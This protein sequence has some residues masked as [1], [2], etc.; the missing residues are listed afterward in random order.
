MEKGISYI[1]RTFD[2][3]KD[4]LIRYTKKYNP[5]LEDSFNDASIGSWLLDVVSNIG[6]NLSYHIDRVYQETNIESANEAESIYSLA[7]NNNV[8]IPGP[9]ASMAE[10]TFSCEIPVDYV[11]GSNSE[12][13]NPDWDYAPVIK[14]GTK[15]SAGNQIFELVEDVDFR[16]QFNENGISNRLTT[17]KKNSNNQITKYLITKTGIVSAGETRIF[18]KELSDD[19]I[20]PFMSIIIP[21]ENVMNIESIIV[22]DGININTTPTTEEFF[23][24][25]EKNNFINNINEQLQVRRFFEDD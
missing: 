25:L 22:K 24:P 7:K 8:K 14:K 4:S 18:T 17:P 20:T 21:D 11:N 15:V 12:M 10:V 6:D 13:K 16:Q 2:D 9:K 1:N 5:E 23:S 3:Y 19:D